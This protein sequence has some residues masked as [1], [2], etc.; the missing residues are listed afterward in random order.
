MI[1]HVGRSI[2]IVLLIGLG[3]VA[4]LLRSK[5]RVV[6]LWFWQGR[7][8]VLRSRHKVILLILLCRLRLANLR[9]FRH[10][11]INIVLVHLLNGRVKYF[12]V[13]IYFFI[14]KLLLRN[15]VI[16]MVRVVDNWELIVDQ[17]FR[18]VLRFIL[19]NIVEL[20]DNWEGEVVLGGHLV[21][22][23]ID[24]ENLLQFV[25]NEGVLGFVFVL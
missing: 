13:L 1:L 24:V 25:R 14:R 3:L 15:E 7:T 10:Y 16:G 22:T 9:Q 4:L 17:K 5:M 19:V 20:G 2:Y 11:S 21:V 23:V 8:E 6:P 12:S 18:S